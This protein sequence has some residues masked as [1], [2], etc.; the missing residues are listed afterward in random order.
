MKKRA[1]KN[2]TQWKR[3]I[4]ELHE[5]SLKIDHNKRMKLIVLILIAFV[6]VGISC[7]NAKQSNEQ[8]L[9]VISTDFGEIKLKLYDD[10]PE[11]KQN[12]LKLIDEG[13]YD[14]TLFHRV[15]KNFMIQGGDPD[16]KDAA[17]GARLGTGNPGYTI[18]AEI[19]PQHFHKKGA[20]AAARRGG[21][22]NPEKRSSG[23]QFYI[24]Q[25]EVFTPGK[26]D[27]M[28]MMLNSRAKNEFLQE[29]FAEAKPKIDEYRKN[30]DQDGFN[31][32]VAELRVAADSAWTEQP[33]FVFSDEQREAYTTIGGYPS[34]DGEYTVFGEVVEG[35]DVLDKIAAVETD[36]Y[37]RP[38]TD[39]KMEIKRTK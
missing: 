25:G 18:P 39:I 2:F 34:L 30:N 11:H 4:S 38:N 22:S 13:Y 27:T 33:K 32:F 36:K 15:M 6:G 31:I 8:E 29:K 26:L 16:S 24:V 7:S 20:L 19:L 28:E 23:S 21:P 1:C 10:T 3:I 17:P 14:G 35:L 12:F 37:D 9:V 5:L